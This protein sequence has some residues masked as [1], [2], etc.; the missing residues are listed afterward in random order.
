VGLN[1]DDTAPG[2]T[3]AMIVVR[4]FMPFPPGGCGVPGKVGMKE[5]TN[6]RVVGQRE[7][8]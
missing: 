1:G 6:D 8:T 2:A 7:I 5:V 3:R 4:L